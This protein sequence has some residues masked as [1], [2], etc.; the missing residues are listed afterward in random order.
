[1][2]NDKKKISPKK[3]SD[4]F[5]AVKATDTKLSQTAMH[6]EYSFDRGVNFKDRT[7]TITGDIETPWFDIV[8]AAMSEFE[9]DSKKG[10][11]IKIF[12]EGGSVYEALAIVGR[13][14]KSK[15]HI[16]TEGYGCVM[17]AAT[18]ILACG[19]KRRMS[20]YGTF[21]HHEAAY[22]VDGRHSQVK[23]YVAHA[24]REELLWAKWMA[25][26]SNRDADF[27]IEFG[28][29]V[30]T[31]FFAPDCVDIGVVDEVF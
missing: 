17:S 24:E 14:T 16:T 23:N 18:I 12:S 20:E 31:F 11:L 30:D 8:D 5:T 10:V 25:E 13:L 9:R 28:K 29:H 15:C 27:W 26:F 3:T 1:M 2:K 4:V 19:D 7:I 22:Q 6:L 21:M